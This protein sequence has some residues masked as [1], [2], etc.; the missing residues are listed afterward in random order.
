MKIPFSKNRKHQVSYDSRMAVLLSHCQ[1]F[2]GG[3]ICVACFGA[4]NVILIFL[5]M[6]YKNDWFSKLDRVLA[7][8][9]RQLMTYFNMAVSEDG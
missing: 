2:S 3:F 7:D 9:G 8:E 1:N 5:A 6:L 4:I